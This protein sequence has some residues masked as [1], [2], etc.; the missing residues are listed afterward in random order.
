MYIVFVLSLYIYMYCT[1]KYL[2][3][4]DTYCTAYVYRM[5]M[6]YMYKCTC[7][8]KFEECTCTCFYKCYSYLWP[9]KLDYCFITN[10]S[11][12]AVSTWI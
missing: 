3:F 2:L 10:T 5:Y 8:L 9:P 6:Q 7:A 12:V 11:L 1:L 4:A